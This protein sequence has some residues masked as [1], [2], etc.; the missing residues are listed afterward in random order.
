MTKKFADL[1][2][3]MSPEARSYVARQVEEVLEEMLLH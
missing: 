2:N 3:D 1:R